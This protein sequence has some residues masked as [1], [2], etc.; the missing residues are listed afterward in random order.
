MRD[1]HKDTMTGDVR[2]D[3][4]FNGEFIMVL[5]IPQQISASSRALTCHLL[6]LCRTTTLKRA[7]LSGNEE[8]VGFRCAMNGRNCGCIRTADTE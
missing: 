5:P 3:I 4:S 8:Q 6:L 1:L 2:K 7:V